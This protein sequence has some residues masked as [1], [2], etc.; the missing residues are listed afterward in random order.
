M[1]SPV[2]LFCDIAENYYS[3]LV[4]ASYFSLNTYCKQIPSNVLVK[5][6]LHNSGV[7]QETVQ[8]T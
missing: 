3:V 6:V 2:L 5:H 1:N 4:W 7:S 8:L